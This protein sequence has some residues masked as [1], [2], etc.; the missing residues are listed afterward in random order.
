[1]ESGHHRAKLEIATF[2]EGL[3]NGEG[4]D[5]SERVGDFFS[6]VRELESNPGDATT[7]REFVE[8]A[9]SLAQ[10]VQQR[11]GAL[12]RAR[13]LG[14]QKAGDTVNS[15]NAKLSQI[16][17]SDQEIM[18]GQGGPEAVDARDKLVAQVSDSIGARVVPGKNGAVNLITQDGAA[19]V[20]GGRARP[21][22][23]DVSAAGEMSLTSSNGRTLGKIGGELGGIFDADRQ[24][25]GS[26]LAEL[27]TFA[28]DFANE[29]NAVHS[30]GFGLDGNTGRPLFTF[31]AAEASSSLAVAREIVDDPGLVA[32]AS[33]AGNVPGGNINIQALA[34]LQDA[35]II[36]G[37]GVGG[38]TPQA[39]L[40]QSATSLGQ[41]IETT[42]LELEASNGALAHLEDVQAS[43]SGVS[44]EEELVAMTEAK[45]A[46]EASAKL[47]TVADEMLGTVLSLR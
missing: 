29:A 18:S 17:A 24:V 16:A 35:A 46:F 12:T 26:Q 21:L 1:G 13:E 43:I 22:S 27:E 42:S 20:E 10:G 5:L 8:R 33:A 9:R 28:R 14:Q 11:H 38:K 36:G 23:L 39:A 41:I 4:H 3:V 25:I 2:T 40:R 30:Q 31:D 44:L 19:L 34:A 32:A 7:R 37:G 47:I 6:T 15:I 45:H